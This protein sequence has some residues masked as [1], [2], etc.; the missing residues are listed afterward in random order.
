MQGQV[1][2]LKYIWYYNFF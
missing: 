1:Y 2:I